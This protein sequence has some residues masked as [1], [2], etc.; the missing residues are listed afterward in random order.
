LFVSPASLKRSDFHLNFV[1]GDLDLVCRNSFLG[2]R[3]AM[4]AS[5]QVEPARVPG[6]FNLQP[7]DEAL[8]QRGILVWA[9][10]VDRETAIADPEE[11][12]LF[13]AD[14]DTDADSVMQL[15]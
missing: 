4:S 5:L 10:V 6:A 12:E 11:R 2:R 15:R 14:I 9:G 1:A 13:P 8:V 7:F 3:M